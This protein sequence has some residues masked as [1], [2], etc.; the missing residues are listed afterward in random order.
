MKA[1][2]DIKI[3]W[4][5]ALVLGIIIIFLIAIAV[6]GLLNNQRF[7]TSVD[8]AYNQQLPAAEEMMSIDSSLEKI[9][10]YQYQYI[11]YPAERSKVAKE[12]TQS[13]EDIDLSFANYKNA[14]IKTG[15]EEQ[16]FEAKWGEYQTAVHDLLEAPVAEILPKNDIVTQNKESLEMMVTNLIEKNQASASEEYLHVQEGITS[17]QTIVFSLAAF[18]LVLAVFF[19]FLVTN[20]IN[21]PI[22]Q[23]VF[24]LSL[25][26]RGDQNRN[27]AQRVTDGMMSRK[28]EIGALSRAFVG[29]SD[30]LIE[31]VGIAGRIAEGDLSTKVT[32]HS[33]NDELGIAL[34]DMTSNLHK[35]LTLIDENA[36]MLNT[37]SQQLASSANEAGQATSQIST[38][39][40]Q[41]AIGINQQSDSVNRTAG[42]VEQMNHAIDS[43]ARGTGEQEEATHKTAEITA[44]LSSAIEQVTGNVQAVV[45]Q[46]NAAT[47]AALRGTQKV[48]DTLKG[49]QVIK[50]RVGV[51][52]DKVHEMNQQSEQIGG[53]VTAIEDIASQTNLLALNAA[54]EA[55][56]AGEAGKGFAVVA[57]EVRKL[58][59]RTSSSTKEI[60][61]LVKS[62]Q[63]IVAEAVAAMN[64]GTKEVD[65]G[66]G[67]A[68]EAGMALNDILAAAEAVKTQAGQAASA[69]E[70]MSAS[71]N[72]MVAAVDSVSQV[73]EE[74]NTATAHMSTGSA[75]LTQAIENIAS[76][77]EQNSA[78]VEQVSASVE[79]MTAQVQEVTASTA[80]LAEMAESLAQVVAK[81]KLK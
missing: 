67:I 62:I 5:L 2:D 17:T 50:T 66:V 71:A 60:G 59:E 79:E 55:A 9:L 23:L 61:A 54:I 37:A 68:N 72:E 1:I 36:V 56:R 73:V 26:S 44:L 46:S 80:A 49:M 16:E 4:K 74:T 12:I 43:V 31:M 7:S 40:Q 32:P 81:F 34:K 21:K 65:R 28:D 42:S 19:T 52:A 69:A 38:T 18:A 63:Q 64:E 76:V 24:S 51:S 22:K 10:A 57:D 48:E 15:K 53:I 13:L 78:A 77:S 41:V 29:T 70:Q 39:I 33:E 58:A 11:L 35:I 27:S 75:E 14:I 6:L 45:E 25:L 3:F 20:S 8:N 30:Y 47:D